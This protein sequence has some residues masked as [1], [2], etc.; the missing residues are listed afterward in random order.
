MYKNQISSNI[1][2][3]INRLK[4][5]RHMIISTDEEKTFDEIQYPL[6]T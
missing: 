1:T 4:E 3:H 5:K 2:R 6:M